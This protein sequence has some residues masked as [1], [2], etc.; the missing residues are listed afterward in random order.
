[1]S[2]AV[3]AFGKIFE[4]WIRASTP[5]VHRSKFWVLFKVRVVWR[6][7]MFVKHILCR[8]IPGL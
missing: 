4:L 1:M 7:R 3:A 8:K 6:H 5:L 2:Y